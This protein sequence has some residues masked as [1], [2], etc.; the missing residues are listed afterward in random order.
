MGQR[1][2]ALFSRGAEQRPALFQKRRRAVPADFF[3][4]YEFQIFRLCG[5][6]KLSNW[7]FP[8]VQRQFGVFQIRFR[9]FFCG[10]MQSVADTITAALTDEG[11]LSVAQNAANELVADAWRKTLEP[12]I[13]QRSAVGGGYRA[14]RFV[15]PQACQNVDT[16]RRPAQ[17]AENSFPSRMRKIYSSSRIDRMKKGRCWLVHNGFSKTESTR[18][19]LER[20]RQNLL[21]K[22]VDVQIKEASCCRFISTKAETRCA[23]R[24][25]PIFAYIG[26]RTW[27]ALPCWKNAE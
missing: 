20:L 27:S 18:L 16:R 3:G 1:R 4:Q 14:W 25:F 23:T 5:G 21:S 26:T 7:T 12:A 11:F 9:K 19:S 8:H 17:P 2:T 24:S 22:N 6:G 15:L 13:V 10:K